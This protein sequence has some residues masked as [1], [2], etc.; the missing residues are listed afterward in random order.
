MHW[1]VP[2]DATAD[3][4]PTNDKRA[5]WA[6]AALMAF[7]KQTGV[8]SSSLGDKEEAFLIV[9]DL[10]ADLAH[11]CDRNHVDLPAALAHAARHYQAET[12]GQGGQ[13]R[14]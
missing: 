12:G 4:G 9:A 11:W 2:F 6:E 7:C 8:I 10:L 14:P 13:L 3:D 5:S 1:P